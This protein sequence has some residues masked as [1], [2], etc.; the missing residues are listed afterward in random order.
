M[1][2]LTKRLKEALEKSTLTYDEIEEKLE[3]E[4]GSVERYAKGKEEPDTET[5][6]KLAPLLGVTADQI[7]FGVERIGEMKAMFP[8]DAKVA[9]TPTSDWRFLIGTILAFSGFAGLLL[10]FMM[11]SSEGLE[12][13]L[14][15]EIMGLPGLILGVICLF[16]IILC[17]ITCITVLN[18]PKKNKKT[19]KNK[20]D[21]E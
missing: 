13:A 2:P 18:E 15:L 17:I 12:L 9:P 11:Y 19:K 14:I 7:L 8:K 6:K 4:K 5:V 20:V 1:S 16:G 3:L 10:M 21:H